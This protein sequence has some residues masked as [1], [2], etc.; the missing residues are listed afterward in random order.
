MVYYDPSKYDGMV[1]KIKQIPYTSFVRV[2]IH[3]KLLEPSRDELDA[4]Y[5]GRL[6][7]AMTAFNS[8]NIKTIFFFVGYAHE[9]LQLAQPNLRGRGTDPC[10]GILV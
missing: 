4:T 8:Q 2:P 1:S 3:W 10:S 9:L 6:D 7:A 5:L